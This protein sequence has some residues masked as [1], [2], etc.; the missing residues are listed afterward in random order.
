MQARWPII[1][2]DGFQLAG[3]NFQHKVRAVSE[4]DAEGEWAVESAIV[5]LTQPR[6]M[7]RESFVVNLVQCFK[8][9]LLSRGTH[10]LSLRLAKHCSQWGSLRLAPISDVPFLPVAC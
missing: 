1:I 7:D 4:W 8:K 5:E 3:P 6:P 2:K 9:S 10:S